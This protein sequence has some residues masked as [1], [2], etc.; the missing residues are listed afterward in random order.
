MRLL[1]GVG[2]HWKGVC[3]EGICRGEVDHTGR[4]EGRSKE[5]GVS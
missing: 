2:L 3:G 4:K 5:R 1:V